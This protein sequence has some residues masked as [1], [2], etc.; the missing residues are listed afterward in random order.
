MGE[1][2]SNGGLRGLVVIFANYSFAFLRNW[3]ISTQENSRFGF[4]NLFVL[5]VLQKLNASKQ[6]T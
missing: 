4:T 5:V 6:V 2:F 1:Q 3:S